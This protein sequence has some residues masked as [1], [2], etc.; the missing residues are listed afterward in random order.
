MIDY[1]NCYNHEEAKIVK[2]EIINTIAVCI[3]ILSTIS[4]PMVA[5]NV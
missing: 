2:L 1:S 5:M 3:S 4:N